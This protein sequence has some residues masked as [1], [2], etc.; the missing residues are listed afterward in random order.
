MYVTGSYPAA[1]DQRDRGLVAV[2][3]PR[4]EDLLGR[5][6]VGRDLTQSSLV[7]GKECAADPTTADRGVEEARLPVDQRAVGLGVPPDAAIADRSA[8][9]L[10][11]E[12]VT[13]GVAPFEVVVSRCERLR[14][15]DAVVS[16]TARRRGDDACEVR[17]VG[18]A[19]EHAEVDAIEVRESGHAAILHAHGARRRC[20]ARGGADSPLR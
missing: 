20:A 6:L 3:R 9:D 7:P 16:L 4:F 1:Q 10:R 19:A 8:V 12:Q 11:D 2:A 13:R 5:V 18:L 17:V 14:R 15:L